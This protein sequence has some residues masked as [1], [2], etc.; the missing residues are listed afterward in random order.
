MTRLDRERM[1][2]KCTN[3]RRMIKKRWAVATLSQKAPACENS[4][5]RKPLVVGQDWRLEVRFPRGER[6]GR[7]INSPIVALK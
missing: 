6:A 2:S 4:K 5:A 3:G 1:A 7:D